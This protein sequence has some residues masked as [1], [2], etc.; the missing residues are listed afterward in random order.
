MRSLQNKQI[1]LAVSGGIAAY[2]SPDVVRRLRD[3]GAEV[4]V[5][6]TQAAQQFIGAL[7]LQAV[8]GHRVHTALLDEEAEAAMGHIELARWAD[9]IVVA[10][11]TADTLARLAAGAADDLLTTLVRAANAPVLLAPAMNQ[12]MWADPLTQQNVKALHQFEYHFVGPDS[13]SQACGDTGAGRM[14]EA[15][16]IA[17]AASQ[18][19]E[20]A[21]LQGHHLVITAGP[22]R[23]PLDPV[24]YI[25]NYSSGKMGFA[26]ARAAVEA[27][28]KVN[29]IAGPV[30]LATPEHVERIDI[31]T[32]QDM[33]K[34]VESRVTPESIFIATAAVA[35][36][37]SASPAEQK[38]K[39]QADSDTLALELIKNPDILQTVAT[40]RDRPKFVVGFAAE[41]ENLLANAGAKLARKQLD[42][43]IAN[44]ISRE[45]IG[46][47][48][49]ENEVSVL[50]VEG[51]LSPAWGR[52]SKD[53]LARKII[54]SI[55]ASMPK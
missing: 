20:S 52:L 6:M 36:F 5:V 41:S 14:S 29:L 13:G 18:L 37:R 19:F 23:E 54:Q 44:D 53:Q 10:P 38:I 33:L 31:E 51:A 26:I 48:A 24:R 2:K 25:S 9:A 30:A 40:A 1:L 16:E 43:I 55:A 28:A 50:T 35:D 42:M 11:A 47:G 3:L 4:R 45:G 27:G 22:T 8:S 34:A 39:K 32:A 46:F 21:A 17:T 15:V 7:S 49:D 12:A